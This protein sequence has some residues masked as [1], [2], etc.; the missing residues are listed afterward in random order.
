MAKKVQ[1]QYIIGE[2]EKFS[3]LNSQ[4]N[5]NEMRWKE[6]A[7][8]FR[9]IFFSIPTIVKV[10]FG[11]NINFKVEN[12]FF[13]QNANNFVVKLSDYCVSKTFTFTKAPIKNIRAY[14]AA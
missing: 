4:E 9:Q 5:E 1:N 11:R 3:T 13:F 8:N 6:Y 2:M 10:V 7:D 14:F 12:R